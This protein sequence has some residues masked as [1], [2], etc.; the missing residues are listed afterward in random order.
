MKAD[1][2]S[3]GARFE[4]TADTSASMIEAAM[5]GSPEKLHEA[6]VKFCERY[7]A[8]IR[9]WCAKHFLNDTHAADEAASNLMLNIYQK[10]RSYKPQNGKPFRGWLYT[11]TQ[12]ECYDVRRRGQRHSNRHTELTDGVD[13]CTQ[14]DDIVFH[15]LI[16]SERRRLIR[17]LLGK[18]ADQMS[19]RDKL[20]LQGY[21]EERTTEQLASSNDLTVG[22]IHTAMSR[23]RTRLG[24]VITEL[25]RE[26]PGL[27]LEDLMSTS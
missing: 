11:V 24:G 25:L 17:E 15:L 21:L 2:P 26:H 9:R 16:D 6:Y 22:A 1:H 8:T 18:A 13:T 4:Q 5:A 7:F 27:E 14:D 19:N 3:D 10:L 20:I 23:L 12:N